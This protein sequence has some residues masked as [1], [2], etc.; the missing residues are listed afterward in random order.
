MHQLN[1]KPI[2]LIIALYVLL[3]FAYSFGITGALYYDDYSNLDKLGNINNIAEALS[4]SLNGSAGPLGRPIALITFTPW[5]QGWPD[6]SSTILLV[7]ILIHS[8]N[9]VLIGILGSLILSIAKPKNSNN[10][11]IAWSAA[12]LWAIMPIIASTSLIAIQRMTS[13]SAFFMLSGLIA[14]IYAIKNDAEA[15]PKYL[16]IQISSIVFFTTLAALSKENGILLPL[17]ALIIDFIISKDTSAKKYKYL[18]RIILTLPILYIIYYISPLSKDMFQYN[19]Y[20]GYTPLERL[21]TQG[22]ILLEYL[23]AGFLPTSPTQFS[24][25]HDYYGISDWGIKQIIAISTIL[26]IFF[27]SIAIAKKTPWLLFGTVWF[28]GSHII[29][30]TTIM[31][32]LYFE[33][34]NYL[35]FYG[36]IFALCWYTLSFRGKISKTIKIGLYSYIGLMFFVLLSV[37]ILWGKPEKAA[38]IWHNKHPGS[39]RAAIHSVYY[40]LGFP[41]RNLDEP[42]SNQSTSVSQDQLK[43]AIAILDKVSS[44][45]KDCID[46]RIMALTYSCKIEPNN[47]IEKRFVDLKEKS[48]TGNINQV[49]SIQL[50]DL[51]ESVKNQKCGN[52]NLTMLSTLTNI[53]IENNQSKRPDTNSKILF[54]K[55]M[56]AEENNDIDLLFSTLDKA[57]MSKPDALP[58]LQYQLYAYDKINDSSSALEAIERRLNYIKNNPDSSINLEVIEKIKREHLS[59]VK[60]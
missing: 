49:I 42:I 50:F 31:L 22:M 27:I 41:E 30:S 60:E 13:L 18:R 7:N 52:I 37:T 21:Y 28:F 19:E 16:F 14:Y 5:A 23:K 2:I 36:Y 29:E 11:I 56:I 47:S 26:I 46:S 57:E 51:F 20:R 59:Q 44:I 33:H 9:F 43:R 39:A 48:S 17:Y 53:L 32:E 38:E 34:R 35:A 24:P 15:S 4:F 55:A 3:I 25:F 8:I 40:E 10:I 1:L 54:V 12:F 45:C 58:I 6:N